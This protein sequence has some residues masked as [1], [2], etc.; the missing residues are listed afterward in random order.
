MQEHDPSGGVLVMVRTGPDRYS[1]SISISISVSVSVSVSLSASA[2]KD[3]LKVPRYLATRQNDTV[4]SSQFWLIML[5]G[6]RS[7]Y[8]TR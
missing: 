7:R 6:Q 2:Q 3:Y 5:S 8:L 4:P 1:I